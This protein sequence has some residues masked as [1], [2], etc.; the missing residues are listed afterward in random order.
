MPRSSTKSRTKCIGWRS[1]PGSDVVTAG[2]VNFDSVR[3]GRSTQVSVHLQYAPPAGKAGRARGVALRREPIADDP[4]GSAS[5]QAAARGR[6]N[7][8]SDAQPHRRRHES[9]LLV[10]QRGHPRRDASPTR[11][12][13]PA[14]RHRQGHRDRDL[15]L[16]PAPLR[17]L[18][19]DDAEG[20]HPRPR[21]HGRSGRGRQA[22]TRV[23]RS[24]TASSCRSPS[25]AA[26]ASSARN[27][28]GR[29]ATTRTRTRGWPRSST[30][31]RRPGCSAIRTCTAATRAARRST[32]ACRSPTSAR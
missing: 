29:S 17:R 14:R 26:A 8:T 22:T 12:P 21:V 5:L 32:C 2:S 11:D 27:S 31:T 25:P 7:S 23:S 9:R 15:R 13:Q 10:R 24:A 16:R 3:G 28:C 4:R 18:H 1:L 20:R 30:A 6:R 19:P